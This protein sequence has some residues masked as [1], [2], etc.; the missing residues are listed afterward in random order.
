MSVSGDVAM[1]Q[2]IASAV[3]MV[4]ESGSTI[5]E[6][7][8]TLKDEIE[9]TEGLAFLNIYTHYSYILFGFYFDFKTIL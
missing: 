1:G 6:E 9:F 2:M 3:E 4:G 5:V 8:Q 7:S